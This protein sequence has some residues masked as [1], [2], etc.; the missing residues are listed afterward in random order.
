MRILAVGNMY[1]PHRLGGYEL[2]WLSWVRH[3]ESKGHEVRVLTTDFRIEPEPIEGSQ[4]FGDVHRDLRWYWRAHEFPRLKLRERMAIE[5][6][7]AAVIARHL[8]EFQPDVVSWWA[9]AGMSVAP[10]EQVRRAGVPAIGFLDDYWL[11]YA[12]KVDGWAKLFLNRPR[13]A[14]LVERRTGLITRVDLVTGIRY[15]FSSDFVRQGALRALPTLTETE[16]VPHEP[17]DAE[18]FVTVPPK[19][20]SWKL[21]YLGRV[22]EVKGVDLAVLS[23]LD[24]PE[25]ATLTIVGPAHDD[26]LAKVNTLIDNHGLRD[27][28]VF[29]LHRR[30]EL[31]EV[32]AAADA[33]LFPVRWY[34]PFGIVPLE[35]MSVGRPVI[36]TGRGGSGEFLADGENCLIFNPDRGP[37]ELAK[38]IMM[39]A[40]DP[41]LRERLRENGLRTVKRIHDADFNGRVLATAV[42]AHT[43]PLV[44]A[45]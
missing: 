44:P 27:R 5:R 17:P 33:V 25:E 8:E 10:I 41:Q 30:E 37:S 34:E 35:A 6:H 29:E 2:I 3:A 32:Y 22:E 23:L 45:P 12:P 26:Y 36:A 38:R 39:L 14:R 31:P 1:P 16:V 24:L 40:E 28:I 18:I 20:W 21:L 11:E 42:R 19:P 9:M 4:E 43:D 15:V 7:N 13:L